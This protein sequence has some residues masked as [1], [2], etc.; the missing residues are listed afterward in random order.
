MFNEFETLHNLLLR[1]HGGVDIFFNVS[2]R[3]NINGR[4][5]VS[6]FSEIEIEMPS[7]GGSQ[8]MLRLELSW[9]FETLHPDFNLRKF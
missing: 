3:L 9:F 8:M 5:W 6:I 2:N 4:Q 7:L 1:L